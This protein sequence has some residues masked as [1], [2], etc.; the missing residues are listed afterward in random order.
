MFLV[1]GEIPRVTPYEK[2]LRFGVRYEG[3]KEEWEEDTKMADERFLMCK[4]KGKTV[5]RELRHLEHSTNQIPHAQT[6]ES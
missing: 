2:G 1:S 5:P 3:E 4:I 6:K